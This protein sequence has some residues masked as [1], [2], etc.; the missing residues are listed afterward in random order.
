MIIR[1]ILTSPAQPGNPIFAYGLLTIIVLLLIWNI[2]VL[3]DAPP[4]YPYDRC[5]NLVVALMLL[6]N[7]LAFQFRWPAGVAVALRVL[8]LGW[9]AFG[10]FYVCYESHMLFPLKSSSP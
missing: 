10:L 6:F 1:R 7:H 5:G 3:L 9:T 4:S 2:Q 8:A